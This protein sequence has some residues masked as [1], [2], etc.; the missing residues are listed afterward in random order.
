MTRTSYRTAFE[1]MSRDTDI[2]DKATPSCLSRLMMDTARHQMRDRKPTYEELFAQGKSFVLVRLAVEIY[3]DMHVDDRVEV[4][5][6]ACPTK[7]V[8]FPR[9]FRI[10]REGV[11]ISRAYS[12]WAV[13]NRIKGGLC[14]ASEVDLSR[15]E[16]DE[17]YQLSIPVRF[18]LSK[19]KVWKE[20]GTHQVMY[21][22]VDR[23]MHMNNTF[24]PN[25]LWNRIPE[26]ETKKVTAFSLHFW[27]EAPL[28]ADIRIERCREKVLLSADASQKKFA[29]AEEKSRETWFFRT[30]VGRDKNCEALVY[31][32]RL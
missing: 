25:M 24:Y 12:E 27:T 3:Q 18:R 15:Y 11:L 23:N 29:E 7:G 17:P 30:W 26:I 10:E 31:T 14:R 2:H 6:W 32:E 1:I 16:T 9:C 8:T 21:S 22:E 4:H 13:A 19:D 28:H 5:T 20:I